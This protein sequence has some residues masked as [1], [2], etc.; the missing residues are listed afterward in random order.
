[1]PRSRSRTATIGSPEDWGARR[2]RTISHGRLRGTR[3]S[4]CLVSP[5]ASIRCVGARVHPAYSQP[6]G[7]PG[8]NRRNRWPMLPGGPCRV[9]HG[10]S[11]RGR[12][13]PLFPSW[14][15]DGVRGTAG[16][17]LPTA[18]EVHPT[19][20]PRCT[21]RGPPDGAGHRT[22]APSSGAPTRR[23]SS[24]GSGDSRSGDEVRKL[25]QRVNCFARP[26]GSFRAVGRGLG[27][28]RDEDGP[29]ADIRGSGQ[30][31]VAAVADV[32]ASPRVH[33]QA[34]AGRARTGLDRA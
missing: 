23:R 22:W 10:R 15:R 27:R 31:A 11:D 6:R 4:N 9:Q 29:H 21:Q 33:P 20:V 30:L 7:T 2:R 25:A 28:R 5:R 8:V 16:P 1:M 26:G 13:G 14:E 19:P 24:I 32:D 34:F 3:G 12:S 18:R 17:R